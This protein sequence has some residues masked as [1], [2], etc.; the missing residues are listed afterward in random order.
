MKRIGQNK[1]LKK[2]TSCSVE[3]STSVLEN[4]METFLHTLKNLRSI[5]INLILFLSAY[6]AKHC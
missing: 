2:R 1:K 3:A 6:C 5:T 4:I